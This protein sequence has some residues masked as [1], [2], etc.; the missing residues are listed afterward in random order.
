MKQEQTLCHCGHL[1]SDHKNGILECEKECKCQVVITSEIARIPIESSNLRSVGYSKADQTLV[2]EF[3]S[4]PTVYFYNNV[5]GEL[6]TEFEK[7]FKD[8]ASSSGS[9]A[10]QHFRKLPFWGKV[11]TK[12]EKEIAKT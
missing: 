11:K 2:I 9:F 4:S 6:W 3:K 5:P 7:T 10:A 1:A 12:E 8:T